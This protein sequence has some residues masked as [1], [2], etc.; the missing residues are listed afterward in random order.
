MKWANSKSKWGPTILKEIRNRD[1]EVVC[2]TESYIDFLPIGHTIT[3]GEDYGYNIIPGRRKVML[4][5]KSPWKDIDGVGNETLP[6]GRFVS[7]VTSTSLGDI[8]FLGVCIP[9]RDTHVRTG[10]KDKAMW[11]EHISYLNGFK[12]ILGENTGTTTIILGDFNERIPKSGQPVKV[13]NQL[14]STIPDKINI[15]TT[16]TIP[17]VE[18]QTI[19]HVCHTKDILPRSVSAIDNQTKDGQLISDH[20]GIVVDF[21]SM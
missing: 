20:F 5:S 7:G 21:K 10:R 16:G 11:E 15:A 12:E 19:D 8:R 17:I 4:W 1:P 18:K 3:S 13:Y 9:W 14:M 6:G 2:M